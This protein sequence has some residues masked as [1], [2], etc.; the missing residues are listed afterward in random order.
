MV[1]YF[2]S[3]FPL[4]APSINNF[5]IEPT[6]TP[7]QLLIFGIVFTAIIVIIVIINKNNSSQ[8][9]G[10]GSSGGTGAPSLLSR[11]NLHRITRSIG[12]N[13]EQR[14]MLDY[15][16]RMDGVTDYEKSFNNYTLLDR[17]FR[18][19][20]RVIEQSSET[21]AEAHKKLAVL[22]STRNLLENSTIGG[23]THTRQIKDDTILTVK[24]GKEKFEVP[25]L[26]ARAEHLIVE[27]PKNALGSP[28]KL[29][30]SS[31]LSVVFFT[32]SNKGFSFETRIAGSGTFHG[33]QALQLV[34]SGQLKHLSQRRFRRRAAVI[35][36]FLNLVYVEGSGKKQRLVVDKRR[37]SGSIADIS[38]GG[39]S[40]KSAAPVQ[41]GARFKIEFM[42]K[43]VSVAALGQVL[44]TNKAG[45]NT[46]IHVRFLKVSQKSMNIINAY[47]YE[48]SY[49]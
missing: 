3:L 44:R 18:R 47:V 13:G 21:E 49:E 30:N 40:I 48:Y 42:Q 41:V 1:R 28:I 38:V 12:L 11:L 4:Q 9:K 43:N 7:T 29:P 39:C 22:F 20:Y 26:T 23:V 8:S 33:S 24:F 6:V 34:H 16:F 36:C 14:K 5:A 46:T 19:A 2:F 10:S 37:T 27:A 25:I 45:M 32:K 15:V 31:A 35:A 17:H